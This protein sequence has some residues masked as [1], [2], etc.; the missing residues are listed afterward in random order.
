MS[1][2]ESSALLA[3]LTVV[4]TLHPGTIQAQSRYKENQ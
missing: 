3:L 1:A 2:A 4:I